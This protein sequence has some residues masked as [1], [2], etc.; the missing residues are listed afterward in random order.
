MR[1]GYDIYLKV[2]EDKLDDGHISDL[3]TGIKPVNSLVPYFPKG[4]IPLQMILE[5]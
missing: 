1:V 5:W 4:T 3:M 2:R